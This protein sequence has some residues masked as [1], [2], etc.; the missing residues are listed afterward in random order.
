[1]KGFRIRKRPFLRFASLDD[2]SKSVT[3]FQWNHEHYK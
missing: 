2:E 3:I 1:M